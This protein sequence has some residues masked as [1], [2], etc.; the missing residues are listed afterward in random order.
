M[1]IGDK[2]RTPSG[3]VEHVKRVRGDKVATFESSGWYL[4]SMLQ[5]VKK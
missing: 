2:V 1:K 5:A 3:K 4:K